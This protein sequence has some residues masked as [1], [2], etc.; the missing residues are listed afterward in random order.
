MI[1]SS[2]FCFRFVFSISLSSNEIV[3][4]KKHKKNKTNHV[5]HPTIMA[6]ARQKAK[7]FKSAAK[8][9]TSWVKVCFLEMPQK[10]KK[11]E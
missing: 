9:S 8:K 10:K 5:A 7:P 1:Q 6:T 2:A 11:K 3:E 4:S